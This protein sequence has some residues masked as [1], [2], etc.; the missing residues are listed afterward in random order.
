M[1]DDMVDS[2]TAA[3]VTDAVAESESGEDRG[4]ITKVGDEGK[5]QRNGRKDGKGS[6]STN[7]NFFPLYSCSYSNSPL[8]TAFLSDLPQASLS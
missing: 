1:K 3:T 8:S 5:S 7:L 2:G 6:F 4:A